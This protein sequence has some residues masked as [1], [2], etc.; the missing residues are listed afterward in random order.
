MDVLT[1][2]GVQNLNTFYLSVDVQEVF[3]TYGLAN[4]IVLK[5]DQRDRKA[6]FKKEKG[7]PFEVGLSSQYQKHRTIQKLLI[8]NLSV[9]PH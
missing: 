5:P 9:I 8:K 7:L 1:G 2:E 6:S 3:A 4:V